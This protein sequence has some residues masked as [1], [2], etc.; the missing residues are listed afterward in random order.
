[1]QDASTMALEI[2]VNS[3]SGSICTVRGDVAWSVRDLKNA[4]E[5]STGIPPSEQRLVAD[6]TELHDSVS[7]GGLTQ[8]GVLDISLVR[9]TAEHSDR[10]RHPSRC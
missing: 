10:S 2:W 5:V 3:L 6:T 9:R 1:M 4:V 7:L 8:N